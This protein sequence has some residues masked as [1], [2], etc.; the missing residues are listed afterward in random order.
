MKKNTLIGLLI[1]IIV[2][3]VCLSINPIKNL[4]YKK[5]FE[6]SIINTLKNSE[7]IDKLSLS[8]DYSLNLDINVNQKFNNLKFVEQEKII[9]NITNELEDIW[10]LYRDN[11]E[12]IGSNYGEIKF[13]IDD[14]NYYNTVFVSDEIHK[15][16]AIT[17]YS[18]NDFLTE[19]LE[20]RLNNIVKDIQDEAVRDLYFKALYNITDTSIQEQL[21]NEINDNILKNELMYLYANSEFED[22]MFKNALQIANNIEITYKDISNL[23]SKITLLD[24]LQGTY[25]AGNDL[26]VIDKW[27]ITFGV[28]PKYNTD[29]YY[30]EYTF[31]FSVDNNILKLDSKQE[32]IYAPS[33]FD[34]YRIDENN[35]TLTATIYDELQ[36]SD[37]PIYYYESS[38]TIFP[39]KLKEP[40][41]GMTK[42]EA[43]NS[44]WGKPKKINTTVTSYSTHEQ[45]V[46]GNG[47]YLYFD[48]GILTSIQK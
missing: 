38:E 40:S 18:Y 16:G 39:E 12:K 46:Y 7:Y 29:N 44:T 26:I 14:K 17:E 24:N 20:P 21:V 28:D 10:R 32:T 41:I 4:I 47:R 3:I 19:Q 43:E 6:N 37:Y 36:M 48:D 22:G 33:V 8:G 25:R 35:K 45:W 2:I 5:N 15:N 30:D 42:K 1:F 23:I 34:E 13:Y 9:K 31:N 27:K 11:V